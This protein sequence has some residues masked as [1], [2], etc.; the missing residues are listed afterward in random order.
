MRRDLWEKHLAGHWAPHLY[1][2]TTEVE[3][4]GSAIHARM[5]PPAMGVDEDPAT[6][7]AVAALSGFLAEATKPQDGTSRWRVEQGFE[8]GRPSIIDLDM[9]VRGHCVVGARLG[10]AAVSMGGGVLRFG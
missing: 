2:L 9:D 1:V 3:R 7:G 8:L 6:G 10:G 5:F 4:E